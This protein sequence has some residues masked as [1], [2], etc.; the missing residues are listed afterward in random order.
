[1][2]VW[3]EGRVY[4]KCCMHVPEMPVVPTLKVAEKLPPGGPAVL[5]GAKQKEGGPSLSSC[6]F[7]SSD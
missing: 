2:W 5:E 6:L 4:W 7:P 1:M 3:V